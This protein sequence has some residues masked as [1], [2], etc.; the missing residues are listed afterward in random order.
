MF[1]TLIIPA[2]AAKRFAEPARLFIGYATGLIGYV[3]GLIASAVFDL[4][5]GAVIVIALLATFVIMALLAQTL[6][7]GLR[8]APA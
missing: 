3:L 8:A 7:K 4:P 6:P 2:L 1:A 5:T